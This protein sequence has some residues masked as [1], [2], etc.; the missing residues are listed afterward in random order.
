MRE[1]LKTCPIKLDSTSWYYEMNKGISVVAEKRSKYNNQLV[2][3]TVSHIPWDKLRAS[4]KRLD[5][6]THR[7][8]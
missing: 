5:R 6:D 3:I 1:H 2:A 7:G 4:L 8:K